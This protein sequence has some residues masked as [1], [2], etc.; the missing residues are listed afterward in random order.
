MSDLLY[1]RTRIN[2][3]PKS[4]EVIEKRARVIR[5]KMDLGNRLLGGGN[6]MIARKG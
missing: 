3:A 5:D 6:V 1:E 2:Q 4:V